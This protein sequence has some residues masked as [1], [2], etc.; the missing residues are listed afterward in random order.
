MRAVDTEGTLI[1]GN[2]IAHTMRAVDIDGGTLAEIT[3][4]AVADGDSG[5]VIQR[6]ASDTTVTGNRWERCRTGLLA[7]DAG[8]VRYHGNTIVDVTEPDQAVTIGP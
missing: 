6:G 7:W 1:A 3:G 2:A 5:C 8:A 4:N